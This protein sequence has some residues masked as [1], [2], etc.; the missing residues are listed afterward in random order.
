MTSIQKLLLGCSSISYILVLL[1]LLQGNTWMTLIFFMVHSLA[2]LYFSYQIYSSAHQEKTMDSDTE[3]VDDYDHLV[4]ERNRLSGELN[5]TL[6]LLEKTRQTSSEKD[7][8]LTQLETELETARQELSKITDSCDSGKSS[9][10]T[11]IFQKDTPEYTSFLPPV[12]E[13]NEAPQAINIIQIAKET[14]Q[15]LTPFAK[16]ADIQIHISSASDSLLVKADA[17]RIRI[18]FRNIIDNSIKY[19]NQAGSLI[20]TMSTVGDDI[21]IVLKDTGK[22]LPD[23]ETPHIFEINYQGSNRISGNGLGLTQAK[24]IVEAYGGTIYAKS[25]IGKGMGIYIQIPTN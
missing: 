14:I 3:L 21:F 25:T 19:M 22:G 5:E 2:L 10:D 12:L 7:T 4:K 20:I 9:S 1:S 11:S 15:E 23:K 16:K 24:A 6:A 8:R 13:T 18:L 17:N